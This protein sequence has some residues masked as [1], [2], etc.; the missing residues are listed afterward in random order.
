MTDPAPRP[1]SRPRATLA[2]KREGLDDEQAA[3]ASVPPSGLTLTGLV[4][5][6][7]EVAT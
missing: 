1:K 7:A 4:Q 2:M 6:M 3:V 5:H